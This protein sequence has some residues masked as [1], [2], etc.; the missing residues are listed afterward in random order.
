M[1]KIEISA[2]GF[3]CII[4]VALTAIVLAC[5]TSFSCQLNPEGITVLSGSYTCPKLIDFS[6]ESRNELQM[7]FSQEV[8]FSEMYICDADIPSE[9]FMDSPAHPADTSITEND[10]GTFQYDITFSES[11]ECGTTYLLYA[12]VEDTY[13]NTLSFSSGFSGYN[14]RL[15]EI[16]LSEVKTECKLPNPEFI[17]LY[18]LEDGNI[19]GMVLEVYYNTKIN[20]FSF[21]AAEVHKGDY[22]VLHMR[23]VEEGAI[24]ETDGI[25]DSTATG[26]CSDA[27]DFWFPSETK[28]LGNTGVILL[29]ER[30]NGRI[31]DA[32]LYAESS[33][34]AWPKDSMKMAAQN[35]YLSDVWEGGAEPQ[36]AVCSDKCTAT[37]TISRQDYLHKGASSWIV[38]AT[39]SATPGAANATK[40]AD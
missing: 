4:T 28:A 6:I 21:P 3:R 23:T 1:K 16:V 8:M 10:N 19:G 22:I 35:A 37:R 39:S 15:P 7:T 20:S 36:N 12:V 5:I 18:V 40:P 11:F 32:L 31:T 13:G 27:L 17:E 34:T 38:V 9:Q 30:E 29:K 2:T 14:D 26:S 25:T 24:D 33:K